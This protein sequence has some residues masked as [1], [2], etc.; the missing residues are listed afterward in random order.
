MS[1]F[2]RSRKKKK[3]HRLVA[4]EARRELVTNGGARTGVTEHA[5]ANSARSGAGVE[6]VDG[7]PGWRR[8][9]DEDE[10]KTGGEAEEETWECCGRRHDLIWSLRGESRESEDG[11]GECSEC[12]E[13]TLYNHRGD[14]IRPQL[15]Q[16]LKL[17]RSRFHPHHSQPHKINGEHLSSSLRLYIYVI[18]THT[19]ASANPR[20]LNVNDGDDDDPGVS[21]IER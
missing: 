21:T 16:V 15:A 14:V 20:Y 9:G 12:A 2:S 13:Q 5:K 3:R 17:W 7:F 19:L 8:D 10:E 4:S 6:E 18:L 11:S 1:E